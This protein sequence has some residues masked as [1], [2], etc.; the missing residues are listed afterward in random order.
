MKRSG[1]RTAALA[2]LLLVN[3]ISSGNAQVSVEPSERAATPTESTGNSVNSVDLGS[4]NHAD[5]TVN[6]AN[7]NN[8]PLGLT[9]KIEAPQ[10]EPNFLKD[11]GKVRV[12]FDNP[13]MAAWRRAGAKGAGFDQDNQGEFVVH[14]EGATFENIKL[15]LAE[16]AQFKLIFD[17]PASMLQKMYR[18]RVIQLEPLKSKKI[19][20]VLV[21]VE[22]KMASRVTYEIHT[23]PLQK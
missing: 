19:H 2:S 23:G 1:I 20:G 9:L 12:H 4:A 7:A 8:P 6:V 16:N 3:L 17:R 5:A 21:C 15:D 10:A 11:G 14:R 13:L 22:P 18:I